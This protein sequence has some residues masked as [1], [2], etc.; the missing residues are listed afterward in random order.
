MLCAQLKVSGRKTGVLY[1]DGSAR[2]GGLS[3]AAI[4]LFAAFCNLAAVAIS[5]AVA[6][7]GRSDCKVANGRRKSNN[8]YP[9]LVG[10]SPSLELLRDRIGLAAASPLDILITGES[11]TGKELVARAIFRTGRRQ[12]GKFVAVDCG[13]LTDS[14]A[15]AELFGYR[16]GAFTGAIENREGLLEAADGGTVFLDEIS[17]M[18][19]RLQAKLLRVLQER[20]CGGSAKSCPAKSIFRSLRQPTR[21]CWKR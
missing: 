1:A 19:F 13:S 7:Q 10:E 3:E 11:G 20:R 5:N 15:E 17:N 2:A 9:E 18:P 4:S 8:R 14:L 16:K 21:I 12:S 6:D